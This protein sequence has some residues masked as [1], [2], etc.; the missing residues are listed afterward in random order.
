MSPAEL[1]TEIEHRYGTVY[2][3]IK[4]SG[5]PKSSIYA[6]LS[7]AYRG[8]NDRMLERIHAALDGIQDVAPDLETVVA[9][10]ERVACSKCRNTDG[11]KCRGCKN[12][13][14]KQAVAIME[15]ME[16]GKTA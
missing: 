4:A 10:L 13:F 2:K 7:G 15:L 14:E 16:N 11:R 8:R 12:T 3:F 1:R 6:A 9:I 5:L